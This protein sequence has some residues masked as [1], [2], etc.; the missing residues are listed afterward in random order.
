MAIR[1][2]DRM[3]REDFQGE[4]MKLI[5]EAV[6]SDD[7]ISFAGGLPN[8]LSFPVED[9]R[10]AT[11]KVLAEHGVQALQYS[12]VEG[13]KPLREFIAGRY[14]AQGIEASADQILITTGSQQALDIIAAVMLNEGDAIILEKPSYLAA[15]QLFHF[16]GPKVLSVDLTEE[17]ADCEQLA[18]LIEEHHPKFFYA[19]PNFQN[20]TGLTYSEKVRHKLA[21]LINASNTLFV[22]DNPYGDL[23]FSG[24]PKTPCKKLMGDQCVLLGTFSKT[25]SPGMRLGWICC[26]DP[27]LYQKLLDYKQVVD[28][29]SNFFCQM[30]L[31]QY[32]ADYRVEDHIARITQL[33]SHQANFMMDC[34]KKY[35]PAGVEYTRPEGGMFLW[36]T[37]PEGMR[38]VELSRRAVKRGVAVAAG[39]PFYEEERG[40]RT[41]RMNYTNCADED[42]RKGIRMLGE[43]IS[44]MQA[45][46]AA[47]KTEA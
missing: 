1:F 11:D 40:V 30:V 19:I 43:V 7:I 41:F 22:E 13:Y 20:P 4:F 15:L 29:H 5:M 18:Q 26:S 46:S 16:Y 27:Q 14:R 45:E 8:P 33:Y 25:V 32:F 9:I 36:V 31:A 12:A 3:L 24:S 10:R 23:R 38:A 2:A 39:D 17:G 35:F 6:A 37:L 47:S 28:L 44:Q 34:M 42:I 21:G